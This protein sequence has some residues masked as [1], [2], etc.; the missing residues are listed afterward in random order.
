MTVRVASCEE[1]SEDREAVSRL[2]KHYL[3]IEKNTTAVG[4]LLP[5]F[6]S[7][8]RKARQKATTALYTML[9]P[10]VN[11]RRK[12][13]VRSMDSIDFF[14]AQGLSDDVIVT[15]RPDCIYDLSRHLLMLR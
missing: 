7:S 12:A 1:I 8:A 4:I 3:D 13:S 5:W 2:A 15:V 14:I 6:P 9:L 10:Y 11:T